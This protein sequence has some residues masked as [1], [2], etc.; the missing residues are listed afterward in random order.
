MIDEYDLDRN[1]NLNVNQK[2]ESLIW[3]TEKEKFNDRFSSKTKCWTIFSNYFL[4]RNCDHTF[5]HQ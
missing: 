1:V 2:T 5:I 3:T 4:I